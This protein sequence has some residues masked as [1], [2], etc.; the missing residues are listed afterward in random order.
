MDGAS[1]LSEREREILRLV[2]TGVGNKE[3][4]QELGISPNTVKVHVRRI[5]AKLGVET[6][7]AATRQALEMG[8]VMT[9]REEEAQ[10]PAQMEPAPTPVRRRTAGRLWAAAAAAA[11]LILAAALFWGLPALRAA[12]APP[13]PAA[14]ASPAAVPQNDVG[15]LRWERLADLPQ[16]R[17]GMAA[18][19][20][21]G[22]LYVMGGQTAAGVSADTL[23]FDL[24]LNTWETRASLLE[25]VR[26]VQAVV[27][28]ERLYL[29]GGLRADGQVSAALWVYDP[30]A[31]VWTQAAPLPEGRSAAAAAALDGRLYLFGG[32]DGLRARDTVWVYD[33]AQDGWAEGGRLPLAVRGAAAL[34]V[35][36]RVMVMGGWG[37]QGLSPRQWL[38]APQRQAWEERSALPAGRGGMGAVGLA[39]QVYVLGGS[40]PGLP[41]WQTSWRGEAWQ[42]LGQAPLEVGEGAA[43]VGYESRVYVIG[44]RAAQG[45]WLPSV[46][47]YRAVF[48]SLAPALP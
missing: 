38:Y 26:D 14:A 13:S 29:A 16:G 10:S 32:W 25:A 34:P 1:Q 20:F 27:L 24:T 39:G 35:E 17:A 21:E 28:G 33:P 12:W 46:Q 30:R 22:R 44:G 47:A 15:D 36:G 42:A 3:I 18:A 5:F 2:A 19:V 48:T 4:A 11:V 37:E 6:R 41:L 23:M 43:V 7:A 9:A 40:P 8:L 45:E 31:D